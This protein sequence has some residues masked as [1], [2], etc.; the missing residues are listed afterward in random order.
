M[1]TAH[2]HRPP[3]W[4]DRF[5]EW[6]CASHLYEEI[7]GDL[8]EYYYRRVAKLGP[9]KAGIL[10]MVDVLRLFKPY[11]IK[12]N[13]N[14]L[15]HSNKLGMIQSNFKNSFRS[16]LKNK[17]STTL[18]TLGLVTGISS[19][20]LIY[21]W[22]ND[23]LTFDKF[24]ENSKNLYRISNTFVSKSESFSQAPSGPALGA[25]LHHDFNEIRNAVRV[26]RNSG[27][28]QV[29]DNNFFETN[30]LI[31]DSTFFSMFSF[32]LINGDRN[33][34]LKDVYSIVITERISKK[35]FGD[36][37]PIGKELLLDG[38]YNMEV[39]A[40]AK[41][42]PL[43]SQLGFDM[44]IN[45]QYAKIAWD[46]AW[47]DDNWL[48]GWFHTYLLVD[49]NTPYLNL[50]KDINDFI[51]EKTGGKQDTLEIK[52]SYF[53]QPMEDIHLKSNLRYDHANNGSLR[54]V[55][56]FSS[57]GII[58]LLLACI[59]YM[60]LATANSLSRARE[61]GVKKVIGAQRSQLIGQF[62]TESFIMTLLAM[63]FAIVVVYLL[64]PQFQLFTGKEFNDL[65]NT[66]FIILV[67]AMTVGIS[68]ISGLYPAFILSS[69]KPV[70]V[71]KG[72]F[73]NSSHSIWLRKGLIIFQF[74]VTIVLL[75][76]IIVVNSQLRFIQAK[77]LGMDTDE[78]L[79][80]N[81]RG[82]QE[83]RQNYGA[84]KNE[85]LKSPAIK[86][87]SAH[88]NAYPVNGLSNGIT[89][90]ENNEG[91]MVSSSLYHMW[92][93]EDYANTLDIEV[94]AG[95]FFSEDFP[96]DSTSSVVVNEAAV[97]TFGWEN[98]ENAI[99]KRFGTEPHQRQVI[100]VVKDFNFEGLKKQVEALRIM[101]IRNNRFGEVTIKAN[102]ADSYKV[103]S[104]LETSWAK[105][106][107]D[108]PLDYSFMDDDINNQYN[109]ER[110]F[111]SVFMIFSTISVI[112]AC[113]GLFGLATFAAQQRIKEIGI[114]KVLGAS[115][116]TLLKLTSKDF[117]VLIIIAFL[118]AI[119]VAWWG[120]D[121]WL[122]GFAYRIDISWWMF[123]V[124]GVLAIFIALIT[125][126]YQSMKTAMD[127]P[128][129]SLKEE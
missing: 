91:E 114:R 78:V 46:A 72:N 24:H 74:T 22:V 119:P 50:E 9:G 86:S 65:F 83:V 30:M 84:L 96:A 121:S 7:Q 82:L 36:Q 38:T 108:V 64:L 61:I 48:G 56:I 32:E 41:N 73:R 116:F 109:T 55:F 59:N 97:R 69:F 62:L 60:N 43:N 105:V 14:K 1:E 125:V 47:M 93:D 123:I 51:W 10:F 129:N 2:Q 80:I 99:G 90:V 113:L 19:F 39:T 124:S 3:K 6:F 27:Q 12:R 20:L 35:Y 57:V 5:L 128:I 4:A 28:I 115:L 29:G 23:E 76:S 103:I 16:I 11:I 98:T 67:G 34:A 31:V 25:H 17:L 122:Q 79:Y 37:N 18:N 120:M 66:D 45:M 85:L 117:I 49:E 15:Y 75:V 53:L 126:S 70:M 52:Y 13:N 107:P 54:N 21:L 40:V 81:F 44:I 71:L 26:G 102:L 68:L 8:Y 106:L 127:N 94:V 104:H 58:I 112:I 111:K 110:G 42:P 92:V 95:R 87:V 63:L 88:R 89:M 118:V 100:G 101:L 77:D 33:T